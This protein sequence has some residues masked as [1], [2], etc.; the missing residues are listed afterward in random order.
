MIP[1]LFGVARKL[2]KSLLM[3]INT[4]QK[5]NGSLIAAVIITFNPDIKKVI[6]LVNSISYECHHIYIID[7]NSKEIHLLQD[8]IVGVKNITL[9]INETNQG[10]AAAQNQGINAS[11]ASGMDFTL[12]FDQDSLPKKGFISGLIR[13]YNL[14]SINKNV[15]AVGPNLF[16]SRY[17]FNYSF[18]ILDKLGFREKY[19]PEPDETNPVEVSCLIASGLLI[20]NSCLQRVGLMDEALFIDYVDTEWCLRCKSY[21]YHIF[22]IPNITLEH[23]I[24]DSN[25]SLWKYKVPVHSPWRRYYRVR[26]GFK[27]VTMK[28]V[29][30]LLSIREI[31]F[32]FIHQIILL[33]N[34]RDSKYFKY[35]LNSVKDAFRKL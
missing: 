6:D 23:E 22:L 16:D 33:A 20:N 10:I 14:V 9:I 1:L 25:I 15:A 31:I 28:H 11:V 24:G 5:K 17:N 7:N 29:P 19:I 18:L 2:L 3:M 30:K 35:Y 34:T 4:M 27:L 8:F 26:N 32:S 21:N 13:G 12:M